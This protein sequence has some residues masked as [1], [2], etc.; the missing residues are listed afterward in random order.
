MKNQENDPIGEMGTSTDPADIPETCGG[1]SKPK[2]EPG[3]YGDYTCDGGE[4]VFHPF[5]G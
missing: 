2:L 3:Q 1:K 4:W 5:V